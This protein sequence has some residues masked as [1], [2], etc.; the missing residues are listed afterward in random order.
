ME[1][2]CDHFFLPPLYFRKWRERTLRTLKS[3]FLEFSKPGP[4]VHTLVSFYGIL[5]SD[6]QNQRPAASPSLVATEAGGRP[7]TPRQL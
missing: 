3:P 2:A 5:E 7:V 6:P 1:M 4:S